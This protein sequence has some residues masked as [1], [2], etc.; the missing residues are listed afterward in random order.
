MQFQPGQ[1]GNPGGRPKQDPRI[2]IM[3]REKTEEAFAVILEC[4]G[5]SDKKIALKAAEILL[6]RGWGKP[7]QEIS[8][9]DGGP[10]RLLLASADAS[11]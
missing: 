4:L 3:A 1:S 6:D 7:T 10:L 8:G 2:K 11:L 9:P 5:D